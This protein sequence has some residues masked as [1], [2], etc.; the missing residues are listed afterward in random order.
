ME[1]NWVSLLEMS[2]NNLFS[3]NQRCCRGGGAFRIF[4]SRW[5]WWW[6]KM[7]SGGFGNPS[8]FPK[9][10]LFCIFKLQFSKIFKIFKILEKFFEKNFFPKQFFFQ[11]NFQN[12]FKNFENLWKLSL[13][14]AKKSIFWENWWVTKTTW[15][16][17]FPSPKPPGGKIR[18]GPPTTSLMYTILNLH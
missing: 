18:K 5:F 12:F 1:V 16:Y 9:N 11:K 10:R 3:S 8:I 17:F 2:R 13:K 14:N 15:G 7:P 6:E 4:P